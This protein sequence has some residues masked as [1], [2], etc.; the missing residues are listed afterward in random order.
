MVRSLSCRFLR[1]HSTWQLER[2]CTKIVNNGVVSRYPS[3]SVVYKA[4]VSGPEAAERTL[5]EW[6]WVSYV[7]LNAETDWMAEAEYHEKPRFSSHASHFH[8]YLT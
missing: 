2:T 4:V 3:R 7:L 8:M 5:F 1:A 6:A